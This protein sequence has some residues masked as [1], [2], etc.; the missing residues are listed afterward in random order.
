ML[1]ENCVTMFA[2]DYFHRCSMDSTQLTQNGDTICSLPSW[3]SSFVI[4]SQEDWEP[5]SQSMAVRAC[6]GDHFSLI[7]VCVADAVRLNAEMFAH[8][9]NTSY[10]QIARHLNMSASCHPVRIWNFIPNILEPLGEHRQRY[11]VF[12]AA[13]HQAFENWYGSS[14]QFSKCLATASGVGHTGHDMVIHCLAASRRGLTVENPRQISSYLYSKRYGHRPPCFSRAIQ[15]FQTGHSQSWL[16]VGGT[17]SIVGEDS[18]H[19][20]CIHR[21]LDETLQN[22]SSLIRTALHDERKE[23]NGTTYNADSPLRRFQH[24]RVYHTQLSQRARI[25]RAIRSRFTNADTIE[26]LHAQ[27]CRPELLLEIEGLANLND[28]PSHVE[29]QLSIAIRS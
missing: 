28:S 29:N 8:C 3:V 7:S 2:A 24:L 16:M 26:C 12:N 17:A 5:V 20:S 23:S 9:V 22:L 4:D 18:R 14:D 6:Y 21:Q 27:L 1:Y 10:E 25:I 19:S 15:V 11:M 13:R